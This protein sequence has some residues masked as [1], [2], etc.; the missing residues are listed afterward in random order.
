MLDVRPEPM[1]PIEDRLTG[2]SREIV[3]GDELP[4]RE[5]VIV[6]LA[7]EVI[8]PAVAAKK[9]EVAA[10]G[11]K[12]EVGAVS[13]A[14]LEDTVTVLPPVGAGPES[15]TVHK[16][17]RIGYLRLERGG[18]VKEDRLT[19]TCIESVAGAEVPLRDAVMVAL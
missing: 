15:V 14:L 8:V 3:T 6:A 5:A 17:L 9:A 7:F 4:L 18:Q 2:A 1:H 11:T 13:F 10:A 16:V 19:P 12:I